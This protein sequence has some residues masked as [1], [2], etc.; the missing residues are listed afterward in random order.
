M[1]KYFGIIIIGILLWYAAGRYQASRIRV[2]ETPLEA[3]Q[4]AEIAASESEPTPESGSESASG[5]APKAA[6]APSATPMPTPASSA[7]APDTTEHV[8]LTV[9]EDLATDMERDWEDLPNQIHVMEEERGWRVLYIREGSLFSRTGLR[10][11]DLITRQSLEALN[12]GARGG[13]PLSQRMSRILEYTS[14][15]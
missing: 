13:D 10:D 7:G 15:Q 8:N 9:S 14:V 12:A 4:E 5:E 3:S 1:K 6:A 11:G 2:P